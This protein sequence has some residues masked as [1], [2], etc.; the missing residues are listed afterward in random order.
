[1]SEND[2][3]VANK[4]LYIAQLVSHLGGVGVEILNAYPTAEVQSWTIQRNEAEA[5][6]A[7]GANAT[8]EMAPFLTKVCAAHH[9]PDETHRLDQVKEKAVAVKANAD[10]WAE[11]AAY[12]NG[13]RARAQAS[14]EGASTQEEAYLA[15]GTA[16]SELGQWRATSGV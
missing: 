8:V 16:F 2:M 9:G 12:V 7:A 1:M 5:V 10:L 11:L 3:L 4:K 14:I 6:L 15:L 13:L